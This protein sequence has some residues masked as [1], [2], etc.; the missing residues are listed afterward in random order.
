MFLGGVCP[1]DTN[2]VDKLEMT[3]FEMR[4]RFGDIKVI[5]SINRFINVV[6]VL[7]SPHEPNLRVEH[8]HLFPPIKKVNHWIA[9]GQLQYK[10]DRV[11]GSDAPHLREYIIP[12]AWSRSA[13]SNGDTVNFS[14]EHADPT[15]EDIA[16]FDAHRVRQ[17]AEAGTRTQP[18]EHTRQ[19]NY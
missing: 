3:E 4:Q 11:T 18:P 19:A 9:S 14:T 1:K 15:A 13:D 17:L 5:R 10:K 6:F 8:F 7:Y 2:A 16:E 12:A